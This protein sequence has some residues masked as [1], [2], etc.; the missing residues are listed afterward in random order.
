MFEHF[1]DYAYM[2]AAIS[3]GEYRE[4]KKNHVG[5]RQTR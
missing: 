5:D 1:H 3:T 2:K 4:S